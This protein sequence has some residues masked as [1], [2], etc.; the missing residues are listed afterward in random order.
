M[1]IERRVKPSDRAREAMYHRRKPIMIAA[2]ILVVAIILGFAGKAIYDRWPKKVEDSSP[3]PAVQDGTVSNSGLASS[4]EGDRAMVEGESSYT[5][6]WVSDETGRFTV[7]L[8]GDIP[9]DT[10][11]L[12]SAYVS[13]NEG[14][15]AAYGVI[16][17]TQ[18]FPTLGND[19][20]L[21]MDGVLS[22]FGPILPS[23]IGAAM[24]GADFSGAYDMSASTLSNGV[25]AIWITG[26]MQTILVKQTED[27]VMS[28]PTEMY[29]PLCGFIVMADDAPVL[30]WGVANPDDGAA[31]STLQSDMRACADTYTSSV[32][33]VYAEPVEDSVPDG[34]E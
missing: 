33:T 7:Y 12:A 3:G 23:E 15:T 27:G 11:T 4:S 10:S 9:M 24:Y 22:V 25:R 19:P 13:V 29:F 2:G 8:P 17:S 32:S 26:D 16:S 6:A 34:A 21:D 31:V 20:T 1:A 5:G 14:N 18:T 30:I 28:D